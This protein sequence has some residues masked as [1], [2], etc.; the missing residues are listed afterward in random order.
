MVDGRGDL[1]ET[2]GPEDIFDYIYAV[3]HSPT[4]RE[5]YAEF[6]KIDFPRVPLTSDPAL[7]RDLVG[8]GG[9]LV[10]LHLIEHPDLPREAERISYP[11]PG[12]NEV[13]RAHP[14]Y[15]PPGEVAPGEAEPLERGRVYINR[16]RR[17]ADA[18]NAQYFEGIAPEVWEFQ[19]GGY[20]VLDKWLK[21]RRGRT[22]DLDDIDHYRQVAVALERT[23]DLMEQI[24][25]RIEQW[26]IE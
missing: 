24:D 13:E 3:F 7:F 5:R 14:K 23:M 21:D 19:V 10:R 17:K 8:L 20:Q 12:D 6:L 9:E 26:P 15:F 1:E 16:T 2:F 11:V 4:Y 25:A 18:P 22:L